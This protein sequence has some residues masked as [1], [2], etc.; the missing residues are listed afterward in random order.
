MRI[1]RRPGKISAG[2]LVFLMISTAFVSVAL[3]D[4]SKWPEWCTATDVA[5]WKPYEADANTYVLVHFDDPDLKAAEGKVSGAGNPSGGVKPSAEGKFSSCAQFDGTGFLSIP[6]QQMNPVSMWDHPVAGALSLEAWVYVGKYPEKGTSIILL[7][8]NNKGQSSGF[9][10]GIDSEGALCMGMNSFNKAASN[11]RSKPGVVPLSEWTH[12]AGISCSG[13]LSVNNDTLYVNGNEVFRGNGSGAGGDPEK[14]CSEL[15]VGGSPDGGGFVGKIDE[16]RIHGRIQRFWPLDPM[17]WIA[18]IAKDGM[19]PLD[20]V[21]DRDSQ[22]LLTFPFEGTAKPV[23][24]SE[25]QARDPAITERFK[26]EFGGDYVSGVKGKAANGPL[27]IGGFR[28]ADWKSGSMDFWIRP[29]GMNNMSDKNLTLLAGSGLSAYLFNTVNSP[30]AL[31]FFFHD[32]EKKLQMHCDA[33]NT[34]FHPGRWFHIAFTWDSSAINMFIDGKLAASGGNG[35]A[36]GVLNE[37]LFNPAKDRPFGDIDEL[38][39][40]ERNLSSEEVANRYWSYVDPSKMAKSGPAAPISLSAWR[41]P[42]FNTV[43]YRLSALGDVGRIETVQLSL[44]DGNGK[45]V[46]KV[47]RPFS[48]KME[49]LEVPPLAGGTYKF[50]AVVSVGGKEL[51]SEPVTFEAEKFAWEGNELGVTDE[52]FPPFEALKV[53]GNSVMPVLRKYVMNGFGLWDS[54][55]SQGR[56]LLASPVKIRCETEEGR[57][58]EWEFKESGIDGEEPYLVAYKAALENA[59]VKITAYSETEMDGM[60]KVWM[61]L[62]PGREQL[63]I[64]RLWLEIP[65]KASEAPL[66]HED[67]GS[68]RRNYSGKIPQGEGVVWKSKRKDPWRNAFAGYVWVGGIERGIAWFAENDKG[69][70]TE[71]NLSDKPLQE[72]VRE[73]GAVVIR[74]N[75]VNIPSIISEPREII[76]GLQAS[77]AK[78]LPAD[79]RTGARGGGLAVHPWGGLSCAH[80]FPFEDR[81]EVVDKLIDSQLNGTDNS[82]WFKNFQEEH[83]VPPVYGTNPW[84][85]SVAHFAGRKERPVLVYFEEMAAPTDR[86][87]W[88]VYK[89]EWSRDI[90]PCRRSWPG[91]EVFRQG[92]QAN[93]GYRSNFVNSYRNYGAYYTNEWLKRGVGIYWDNSYLTTATNPLTSGAYVAEDGQTQPALTLWNQRE[94]SRRTWNLMH[95][96]QKERGEK[97][98]FLQHMTNTNLL[99]I[100]SWCTTSFDM[101]WSAAAY[102]GCFPEI[103]DPKE[104]FHT[105]LL[106]A[107]SLGRQAGNYACLCHGLFNFNDFGLDPNAVPRNEMD[108]PDS[109]GSSAY[110][111]KREWGMQKV[112]ELPGPANWMLSSAM[113]N[114]A[115]MGFGYDS[116]DVNVHNY[117][118]DVPALKTDRGDVKWLLLAR[119]RDKRILLILQAWSRNP[120]KVTVSFN[121]EVIGFEPAGIMQDMESGK[122]YG[123]VNKQGNE[124][125]L[126]LPYDFKMIS[127]GAGKEGPGIIFRDGFEDGPSLRWS[128]IAPFLKVDGEGADKYLRI[129]KN[130]APWQGP[131][132]IEIWNGTEA[133]MNSEMKIKFRISAPELSAKTPLFSIVTRASVPQF[134]KHGL[135]HTLLQDGQFMEITAD[136]GKKTLEIARCVVAKD[137]RRDNPA[138]AAPGTFDGAWHDISIM[139]NGEETKVSL[140]GGA[141]TVFQGTPSSG[142]GFG[143]RGSNTLSDK[144]IVDISELIVKQGETP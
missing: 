128:Y 52:I 80:K 71:K 6:M 29:R 108:R 135:S 91:L 36:E 62:S 35:L 63:K 116:P 137:G 51:R 85:Q 93:P 119:P 125:A 15:F 70:L 27:K 77:P 118:A 28:L 127:A 73:G 9:M 12:V 10:L 129:A 133:W 33:L 82:A 38:A 23:A 45:E 76:F 41:L 114:K 44:M 67:T 140:D 101:E 115:L 46:L 58:L 120:G 39:F 107:Q 57:E 123:D 53:E 43:W 30:K 16:V 117:W 79:W 86:K 102:A 32:K 144:L 50:A 18:R 104:P 2:P 98:L 61:R 4:R 96:W 13:H 112:H 109:P 34:E 134:S 105:D 139:F 100:L 81:W 138:T 121:P 113:L 122:S 75:L 56:E 11:C 97:L 59:A 20:N 25:M 130:E 89:D 68:L 66:M 69:W 3:A 31:S 47:E 92:N 60:M 64:K 88:H 111:I 55:V 65:V 84:L 24:S 37:M 7:K 48:D 5:F 103:Q 142:T 14:A 132:R 72:I 124:I 42:S 94:Y 22:P 83:N 49:K 21:L 26:V 99:P 131:A 126:D 40:Y 74:V 95:K 143:I 54:V 8:Q 90:L 1:N 19:P 78:P 87:E 110:S 136:P 17:P 141:P 106:Q